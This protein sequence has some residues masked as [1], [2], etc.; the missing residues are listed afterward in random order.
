MMNKW[1]IDSWVDLHGQAS[2]DLRIWI[3]QIIL[4]CERVEARLD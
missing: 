1:A 2:L 3:G 4:Y